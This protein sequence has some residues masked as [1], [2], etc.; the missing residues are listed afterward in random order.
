MNWYWLIRY[1]LGAGLKV[2]NEPIC[3]CRA[4]VLRCIQTH[5][6]SQRE[7]CTSAAPSTYANESV[8]GESY[9]PSEFREHRRLRSAYI[10]IAAAMIKEIRQGHNLASLTLFIQLNLLC[11]AKIKKKNKNHS[12][13]DRIRQNSQGSVEEPQ[14]WTGPTDGSTPL[15]CLTDVDPNCSSQNNTTKWILDSQRNPLRC[16]YNTCRELNQS[17]CR[18][19]ARKQER[20]QPITALLTFYD[21]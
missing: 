15:C 4:T 21:P 9:A 11:F 2:S 14:R 1:I 13:V 16:V 7:R 10:C 19:S 12:C 8:I 17:T 20:W 3:C 6:R 18:L 5:S